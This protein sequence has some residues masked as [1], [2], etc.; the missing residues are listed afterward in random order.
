MAVLPLHGGDRGSSQL[1]TRPRTLALAFVVFFL[2]FFWM[3]FSGG[4]LVPSAGPYKPGKCGCSIYLLVMIN[5]LM[6]LLQRKTMRTRRRRPVD[7]TTISHRRHLVNWMDMV[8]NTDTLAITT[9]V[10]SHISCL[11]SASFPSFHLV[12]PILHSTF[13]LH[14]AIGATPHYNLQFGFDMCPYLLTWL[15]AEDMPVPSIARRNHLPHIHSRSPRSGLLITIHAL[16]TP[17]P[18]APL[19][20]S[21]YYHAR[22]RDGPY[23]R[24]SL[25]SSPRRPRLSCRS[26][27][28]FVST[29]GC[30]LCRVL[31]DILRPQPSLRPTVTRSATPTTMLP[32]IPSMH[33]PSM[34][35]A[36]AASGPTAQDWCVTGYSVARFTPRSLTSR[37][38]VKGAFKHAWGSY[39]RKAW[40]KDELKPVRLTSVDCRG[41]G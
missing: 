16:L 33:G 25:V 41:T 26:A 29:H 9:T 34:T 1:L 8:A 5:E 39:E 30:C 32:P 36:K 2:L 7:G 19:V 10:R 24:R 18:H 35:K 27:F 15:R 3:F 6:R 13:S 4:P 20:V 38:Q 11:T 40:G 12:F 23:T 17:T 21:Y 22:H 14:R 28:L 37:Y 31:A